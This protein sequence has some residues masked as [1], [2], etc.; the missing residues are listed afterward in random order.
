MTK[1]EGGGA[2]SSLAADAPLESAMDSFTGKSAPPRVGRAVPA[3][4]VCATGVSILSTDLYTPSLPHLPELLATD[5]A[6]VQLTM[7]LNLGAYALAQLVH[8]PLADRFGRQRVLVVG[9][10]VFALA[11]LACVFAGAVWPLIAGRIAQGLT[12]SVSSV[13]VMV[14]IRELYAGPR[15]VGIMALYGF[16]VGVVPIAGPLI[17][18]QLHVAFG[19]RSNFAL[20]TLLGLAVGLLVW[21]LVPESGR[22]Q[23]GAL[24]PRRVLAAYGRLLG[25]RAYLRQLLPLAL[26][27]GSLFAFVTAGP[28][29][30]IERHGV[31]TEDYGLYYAIMVVGYMGG[32]LGAAR[33]VGRFSADAIAGAGVP[34]ALLGGL[35]VLL[36][37]CFGREALLDVVAGVT[38]LGL[39]LGLLLAA[40]SV[41]MMDAAG[42][43]NR[44]SGAALTGSLQLGFGAVAG[45]LVGSFHDGTAWPM[46]CTL[47]GFN[48][49]AL[50]SRLLLRPPRG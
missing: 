40:G 46:A 34:L 48:G 36:P 22:P 43:E 47:V 50:A 19:W 14:L 9:L 38:L 35:V 25:N 27:F 15:A 13:V 42:D 49:L 4:L 26:V 37:L 5:A 1:G 12:A 6:T 24:R 18:G 30:L 45:L 31:A 2:P 41:A 17:G 33:L 20:L 32:S 16:A 11:S 3:V 29:L 10:L 23:P 44:G 39:G 28:F 8:G 7:S 21:R